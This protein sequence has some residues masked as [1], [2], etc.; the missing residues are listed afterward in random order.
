MTKIAIITDT[1]SSLPAKLSE[2]LG[3]VQVPITIQFGE[4]SYATGVD[5]NDQSLF[6]L[7][8]A[9][10]SLPTT[11]APSPSAFV[12]AFKNAFKNGA[13]QVICV[14]VSSAISATY[15]SALSAKEMLPDKDIE[16]VD[17]LNLTMAQGFISQILAEKA[18]AGMS[19]E[20]ILADVDA[21]KSRVHVFGVLPTLKYLAMGGRMGKLAAGVA[22]TLNIKPIL[23]SRNGKLDLLEKVRTIKKAEDRLVEL[24][25][26]CAQGKKIERIAMIHVNNLEDAKDLYKKLETA[27]K[28]DIKPIYSEFSAGLSVHAGAGMIGYVLLTD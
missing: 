1:D 14:C 19:K 23:T 25:V 26:E 20:K 6:T 27:L 9:K 13:D 10:G 28:L 11:A 5:I 2:D 18:S 24:A 3:I 15:Q 17:S 12:E 16:V 22:D 7:I 8:D 21:L 4:E